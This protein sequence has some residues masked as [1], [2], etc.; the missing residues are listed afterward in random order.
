M[1]RL[2]LPVASPDAADVTCRVDLRHLTDGVASGDASVSVRECE[3]VSHLMVGGVS[4]EARVG[5]SRGSVNGEFFG[6]SERTDLEVLNSR[7]VQFYELPCL[8][9]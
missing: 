8:N 4:G 3:A 7:W 2:T 6:W 9:K 1:A 5:V